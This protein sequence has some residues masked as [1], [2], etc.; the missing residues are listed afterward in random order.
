MADERLRPS[1]VLAQLAAAADQDPH[2]VSVAIRIEG[3]GSRFEYDDLVSAA[4]IRDLAV[5]LDRHS[6]G[7]NS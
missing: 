3:G 1:D 2:A 5:L 6:L 4:F 7:A